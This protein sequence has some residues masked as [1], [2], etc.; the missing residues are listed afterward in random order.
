MTVENPIDFESI[1]NAIHAC[2]ERASGVQVVWQ[3]QNA[4]APESPYMTLAFLTGPLP[5][6]DTPECREETDLTR[7]AGEEVQLK[8]TV[9][10]SFV[11]S[12]QAFVKGVDGANPNCDAMSLCTKAML[13]L[14]LPSYTEVLHGAN[15]AVVQTTGPRNLN[16]LVGSEYESRAG[17][18]VT[19]SSMMVL[20]EYAGYIEKVHA[21][22]T[23]LGIDE[24]F[25]V[26]GTV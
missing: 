9:A 24:V 10:C 2:V 5:V 4:P 11:L 15:I 19:F 6:S 8:T 21:V 1:R 13:A 22:S 18:D 26:G 7:P 16:A 20:S 3:T 14:A 25:G 12:C 17:F 23:E